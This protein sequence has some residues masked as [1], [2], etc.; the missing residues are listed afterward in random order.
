MTQ[1]QTPRVKQFFS[2]LRTNGPSN[3]GLEDNLRAL[4][5]ELGEIQPNSDRICDLIHALQEPAA[6]RWQQDPVAEQAAVLLFELG[7]RRRWSM[8]KPRERYKN[9]SLREVLG[10]RDGDTF[11]PEQSQAIV[12]VIER[13]RKAVLY[14]V[15]QMPR[16]AG[17]FYPDDYQDDTLDKAPVVT[18]LLEWSSHPWNH[19]IDGYFHRN[20]HLG[21]LL[22]QMSHA[23]FQR[24][25]NMHQRRQLRTWLAEA[26]V[27]QHLFQD[28]MEHN[29]C[30]AVPLLARIVVLPGDIYY[31]D[32]SRWG[33]S[34][35]RES[36]DHAF[37][38]LEQQGLE[39]FLRNHPP[40][41]DI[42]NASP[43][44]EWWAL[45]AG[46]LTFLWPIW[47]EQQQVAAA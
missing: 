7:H 15:K 40:M 45:C 12:K 41:S 1:L 43:D 24:K 3:P 5:I 34:E 11:F 37:Q 42:K 16:Q 32:D 20:D 39:S 13:A 4:H 21:G 19:S 27:H 17:H 18:A 22:D 31:I 26:I 10:R 38:L 9:M 23:E 36:A 14:I 2:K 29:H 47:Q 25:D 33:Q 30:E 28:L 35:R 6:I 46:A 44:H 8:V